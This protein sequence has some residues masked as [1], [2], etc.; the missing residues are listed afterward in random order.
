MSR[1]PPKKE[2]GLAG[3]A[4]TTDWNRQY[5]HQYEPVQGC[6]QR[7]LNRPASIAQILPLV[8]AQLTCKR[9]EA[10]DES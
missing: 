9:K 5:Y 4:L 7:R 3:T 2:R 10:T 1:P 8:L 6:L